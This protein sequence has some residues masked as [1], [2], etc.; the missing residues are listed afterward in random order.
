MASTIPP[1]HVPFILGSNNLLDVPRPGAPVPF[2]HLLPLSSW[3][4]FWCFAVLL[5]CLFLCF[6]SFFYSFCRSSPRQFCYPPSIAELLSLPHRDELPPCSSL[7]G[8]NVHMIDFF[9]CIS[10]C[11]YSIMLLFFSLYFHL[12]FACNNALASMVRLDPL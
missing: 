3:F 6:L 7:Y 5:F 1:P 11:L 9:P 2:P 10:F 12:L 4:L 8:V